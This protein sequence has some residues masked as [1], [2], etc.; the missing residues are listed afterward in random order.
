MQHRPVNQ[1]FVFT[2][3]NINH[4][5]PL[6]LDKTV[7]GLI[8]DLMPELLDL[9]PSSLE[10]LDRIHY[11]LYEQKNVRSKS[12]KKALPQDAYDALSALK[13]LYAQHGV[14]RTRAYLEDSQQR[15]EQFLKEELDDFPETGKEE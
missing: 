3:R 7:K 9:S 10:T 6:L 15:I 13:A 11:Y 12:L 1:S 5:H 4:V 2:P 14:N 8:E